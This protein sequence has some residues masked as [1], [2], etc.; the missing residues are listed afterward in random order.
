MKGS[1]F[2]ASF[3]SYIARFLLCP[4]LSH[5]LARYRCKVSPRV[6][7]SLRNFLAA[8]SLDFDRLATLCGEI[9]TCGRGVSALQSGYEK[10][11]R[12]ECKRRSL[13][14]KRWSRGT[15][16][17]GTSFICQ[18]LFKPPENVSR[19]G[20]NKPNPLTRDWITCA[21]EFAILRKRKR[22]EECSAGQMK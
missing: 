4:Q 19:W 18:M 15:I 11:G 10:P 17:E 14:K 20:Q 5:N 12:I 3:A 2:H 9:S 6:K 16:A 1:T 7:N 22:V 13:S 8:F 21:K